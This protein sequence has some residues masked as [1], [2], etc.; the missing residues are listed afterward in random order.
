MFSQKTGQLYFFESNENLLWFYFLSL[1]WSH[2]IVCSHC[3]AL[4]VLNLGIKVCFYQKRMHLRPLPYCSHIKR[5][6]FWHFLP[7]FFSKILTCKFIMPDCSS[8]GII[9]KRNCLISFLVL[10]NKTNLLAVPI[11][12]SDGTL[13]KNCASH[14]ITLFAFLPC[15]SFEGGKWI[16]ILLLSC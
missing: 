13:V 10:R 16:S 4:F 15:N 2:A 7:T 5:N 9:K 1:F 11:D 12:D 3:S 14:Q 8:H 6:V